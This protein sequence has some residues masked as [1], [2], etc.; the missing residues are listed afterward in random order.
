VRLI[1]KC[2]DCEFENPRGWVTCAR[3]GSLLGPRVRRLEE[4]GLTTTTRTHLAAQLQSA[5]AIQHADAEESTRVYVSAGAAP[6]AG[7][8]LEG[9]PQDKPAEGDASAD[10]PAP[11]PATAPAPAPAPESAPPPAAHADARPLLG[12]ADAEAQVRRA[13]ER[14]LAEEHARLVLVRGVPGA[15]KTRFLHRASEIGARMRKDI[16]V[17]Y[18]ALRSR[19]DGPYAP[20]SRLLLDRFG[21]LPASS[22]TA[23]R[24]DMET[25]VSEA[26]AASPQVTETTHLLGH[27]VGVPF[28][29]SV[30][31]RELER[32]PAALHGQAMAAVARFVAGDARKRPLL[33]LFDDVANADPNAWELIDAL[34]E[35]AVPL[36]IVIAAPPDAAEP[37]PALRNAQFVDSLEL[38]PLSE[39]DAGALVRVLLPDLVDLPAELLAALMHRTAGNPQK[40]VELLRAL[41]DGGLFRREGARVVID[42]Q[43]LEG[44]ALPLTMTDSIRARLS[45]LSDAER[46]VIRDAALVGERFWSGALLALRRARGAALDSARAAIEV[47]GPSQDETEVA[48]ALVALEGKGFVV[49]IADATAPGHAEYTFQYAGTRT[50]V[51]A[52]LSKE[53]RAQ[54]HAVVARWLALTNDL[55]V[56]SM[57]AQLAPHLEHAGAHE[58][59]ARAY[60]QA[61]ADERARMRTTM[62]LVYVEKALPLIDPGDAPKRIDALHE[63]GSLLTTLGRYEEAR[64]AFEEIVRIAWTFGARGRGGAALNRIARIHRERGEFDAALEHLRAALA[65]FGS[66]GDSRGVAS[67]YDDMAQI[68]RMRGEL[69]PALAAAKEALQI[70]MQA[71]D[72]RAQAVS[73]NTIGRIE[74]DLCQYDAAEAR[75][76]KA[77]E[78]RLALPDHEGAVQTRIHL[79]QLAF[80]RGQVDEAVRVYLAALESARELNH[81]RY[82]G[83]ALNFLGAAYLAQG[84][85]DRADRALREAKR[86]ASAL[87]DQNVLGDIERNLANLAARRE[88][89]AKPG[90]SRKEQE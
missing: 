73:L 43:K 5:A 56:E 48:T 23:V 53:E 59:A 87:R 80:R 83:Y 24:V 40:L 26:L 42:Q 70:R 3:C 16:A 9:Q 29:E 11:P 20:V 25:S 46:A 4:T 7:I 68:H 28:R 41:Q 71:Q 75:F 84:D 90:A 45:T 62:A 12:Q 39:A 85:T 50:L 54:G 79:G 61:G 81:Q 14:T 18:A 37:I 89:A 30:L 60:L 36:A 10:A 63:R 88:A 67:S 58:R 55:A 6:A 51:Y 74:L 13:I 64:A 72:R 47:W 21:I 44:G 22:P 27:V 86:L 35:L 69:E 38:R 31:L 32:D 82:Q 19:D 66:V 65:L 77:L 2:S 34:L 8:A 52:D 49:H 1:A 15:G 76:A 33:W 57:A 17:Y 78:I